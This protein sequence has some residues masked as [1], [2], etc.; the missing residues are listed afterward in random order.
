[1]LAL[2]EISERTDVSPASVLRKHRTRCRARR[3][4]SGRFERPTY[5]SARKCGG[6]HAKTGHH[7]GA[8]RQPC[9]FGRRLEGLGQAAPERGAHPLRALARGRK[10]SRSEEHTSELQ[11]R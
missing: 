5:D 11:S 1:A 7:R 4:T 6:C 2:A 8:A 10:P 3:W 9:L